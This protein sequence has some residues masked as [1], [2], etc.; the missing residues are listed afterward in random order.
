MYVYIIY[1]CKNNL[2][3]KIMPPIYKYIFYLIFLLNSMCHYAQDMFNGKI[4]DSQTQDY[5]PYVTI[6]S[7]D[8][9]IGTISDSIG[10]FKIE[11][12]HEK[13][14]LVSCIGYNT[15][16][17]TLSKE[18]N[19]IQ[20]D[21]VSYRIPEIIV[22]PIDINDLLQKV[23]RNYDINYPIESTSMIINLKQHHTTNERITKSIDMNGNLV[24]PFYKLFEKYSKFN[25]TA[26]DAKV[27]RL[28]DNIT[29]NYP[30][31][32]LLSIYSFPYI[33]LK[34]LQKKKKQY[35]ID[36]SLAYKENNIDIYKVDFKNKNRKNKNMFNGTFF[37]ESNSFAIIGCIIKEDKSNKKDV[38]IRLNNEK[39]EA[40]KYISA[41]ASIHF[42]N[43]NSK[44]QVSLLKIEENFL[45]GNEQI[46]I[47]NEISFKKTLDLSLI[48]QSK[49]LDVNKDLYKQ[50]KL[51]FYTDVN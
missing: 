20:L 37:I 43:I 51:L 32:K 42:V 28:S 41:E 40:L 46:K 22:T 9:M 48:P 39:Q 24:L 1:V 29:F 12:K 17:Y 14:V 11:L 16:L 18:N 33:F 45:L 25:L 8:S 38:Y 19:L 15:I 34:H 26:Y 3:I 30:P 6:L 4:L 36:V 27:E 10:N 13:E 5:L 7:T 35:E 49:I 23:I 47:H 50:L 2:Y 44:Y 31:R 21:K